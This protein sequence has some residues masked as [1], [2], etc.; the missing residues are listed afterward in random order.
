MEN[1]S[2]AKFLD[3]ILWALASPCTSFGQSYVERLARERPAECIRLVEK[4]YDQQD[5]LLRQTFEGRHSDNG[6]EDV[7]LACMNDVV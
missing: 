2:S 4:F 6:F 7:E 5:Y 1:L 3:M